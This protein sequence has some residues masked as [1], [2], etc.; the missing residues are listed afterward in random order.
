M[1]K[2]KSAARA[3][4]KTVP[5]AVSA[6]KKPQKSHESK[7]VDA[8]LQTTP[9]RFKLIDA[10]LLML[11]LTGV[12]QFAYCVLLSNYPFNAFIS[13]FAATI[14]QFVLALSLRMQLA[15]VVDGQPR[16]TENR[17]FSEFVL[18]SVV[19]HFFVV[20]FLG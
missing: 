13:G 14:G 10:F 8:Y 5:K 6:S 19:L 18:A 15:S 3:A 7:M 16:V 12:L 4:P 11:F 20:N 2:G 17:A 9:T 1:T